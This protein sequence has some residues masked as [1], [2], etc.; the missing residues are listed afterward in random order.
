MKIN[1]L[2]K[3][4]VFS[5]VST[6][7][8]TSCVKNDDWETPPIV[9]NNRFD[10]PTISMADFAALAPSSGTYKVPA[11]GAPVIFDAYIVSS[12]EYGNF[13]KT[14]S[15]QDKPENPTVG[16]SIE[17]DKAS[18]YADFPVGAHVRIKANGLVLGLD[19]GTKKIGSV[20]PQYAIG[21]IPS[22]LFSRYIS[23]VC[24]GNA[25]DIATLVPT[26][27]SNLNDA[28]N[29]KY[30]NTLVTVPKVQFASSEVQ[31]QPKTFINYVAGIG[32]DTDRNI[33]DATGGSTVL[34]NSGF[35]AFGG[36]LLPT[37][38]GDLTFVVSR[39]NTSWQM[40]IRS[41]ADIKFDNPR[42]DPAPPKGGTAINFLGSFT[43]DFNSYNDMEETFP[44]YVNDPTVGNRYWQIRSFNGNKYIQISANAGSGNYETYFAVP[45][46]FTAA[47]NISFFVNVGFYNGAALKVYTTTDYTALGDITKATLKDITS[48]FNIPTTP[49]SGYGNLSSAGTYNFPTDLTGKG[50]V[51]FKYTGANPGTTTTIQIDDIKVQ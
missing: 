23:G 8:L 50:Y 11:D 40:Y 18:N 32:A 29:E 49:T 22:V 7:A 9:C 14:I 5:A 13:Y 6:V 10:A 39:Y 19:R 35:C 1:S 38:N 21:R 28:K 3:T 27:V 24:N 44:K 48:S 12:D 43:E 33:E 45:V 42:Y 26:K 2:F 16:L 20:D 37:G 51:L 30:L 25:M 4:L 17:V 46:D 41:K 47:N 34:R 36:D 31:P 15:I